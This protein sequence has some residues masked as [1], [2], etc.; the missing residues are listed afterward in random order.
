MCGLAAIF[1][2]SHSKKKDTEKMISSIAHRGPDHQGFFHKENISMGSCRLSIFDFSD[3]GNMPMSDKSG[4]YTIIYNGEIYNFK[5]LKK[6]FNLITRSNSDTEILLELFAKLNLDCLKHLNGIFAFIIFDNLEEKAYCA[7]DRLGVKPLYFSNIGNSYYFCSEIKGLLNVTKNININFEAVE[8]YLRTSYYDYSPQSFYKQIS[9]VE[10]STCLIFD[11]KN[12]DKKIFKYWDLNEADE[13]IES[14][15]S[16]NNHF[17]NSLSLQQQSDTKVGLNVSTGIDSNLMIS[18]L[19]LINGGQKKINANSFYFADPEFDTRNDLKQMSN[20]YGWKINEYEIT[21]QDVINKFEN[22]FK[23]QDE[24]FPGV[25]TIAKDLLIEKAYPSDCKVILE[26]QGG[27]DIAAG[28]KYVFPL[29]V[30]DLLKKLNFFKSFREVYS[31]TQEEGLSLPQFFNFFSNSIKGYFFGGIS[32]D[33]TKSYQNEVLTINKY[34]NNELYKNILSKTKKHETYLKKILYRD[35]FFCKLSRILRSCDRASMAHGKELRVP[36]LDHNLVK[37]F[38][39]IKN[40]KLISEGKL[41]NYYKNFALNKFPNNKFLKKNK[42]YLSDP[43]T[44]WL[45][46]SLFEWMYDKLSSNNLLIDNLIDKKKLMIYLNKFKTDKK[47]DN[48]NLLWQLISVEYL[49]ENNKKIN[50]A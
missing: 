32:A 27:D 49:L 29:Y 7:R 39:S 44:K 23:S 17:V 38:F 4:R 11:T 20:H 35:L 21:S 37:Y 31:F 48:S 19:D 15:D 41:R 8:M 13:S 36:F 14:F 28:Y 25:V 34:K 12:Y 6:K 43:Q 46:S 40:E 16:L 24:P 45:K 42:L 1:G 10:Q 26:G 50:S 18:Y 9:Q 22:V 3:K 47:I 5:E 30:L 33:G 2:S